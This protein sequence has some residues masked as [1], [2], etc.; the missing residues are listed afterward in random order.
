MDDNEK[1]AIG[2]DL[3][4][5]IPINPRG[6]T[7]VYINNTMGLTVNLPGTMNTD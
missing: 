6:Y 4:V 2:R 1:I 3:I 5:D 7:D